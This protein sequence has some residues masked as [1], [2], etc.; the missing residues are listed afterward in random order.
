MYG[1]VEW[2]TLFEDTIKLCE[3]GYA[4]TER[5][6]KALEWGRPTFESRGPNSE[7]SFLFK[8]NSTKFVRL[9]DTIKRPVL[10]NSLKK[11]AKYGWKTFYRGE[12]AESL[13]D[14]VQSQGGILTMQ[15]MASYEAVVSDTLKTWAFG[16]EI[17]TCPP[18]CSG[19]ALIEG[20]N[21]AEGLDM[22]DGHSP[23]VM[24][25]VVETMKWL[26]AGRTELG[27][28]FDTEYP[29][30]ARVH[31]IQTKQFAA[32]VRQNISDDRTYGWKHYN[33]SYQFI[34][35]PGT[36]HINTIDEAGMAV[37]LTSTVNLGW[38]AKILDPVTG[39]FLYS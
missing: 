33:P 38:G 15:D 3:E 34:E 28:P 23:L 26:S 17:L 4:V 2:A 1:Q 21:I 10:G 31:E 6:V 37:S 20:L 16:I 29:N 14:Y 24:H 7:W 13:V 22:T 25:R 30:Q 35:A 32:R 18:P 11:I 9:G 19:P 39:M 36:S 8:P 12:M 27:D 5:L